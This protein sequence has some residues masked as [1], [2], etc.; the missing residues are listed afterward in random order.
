MNWLQNMFR[1]IQVFRSGITES[2]SPFSSQFQR[3]PCGSN[4]SE[5]ALTLS[6]SLIDVV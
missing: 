2:S 4:E 5:V 6:C 3:D 1:F